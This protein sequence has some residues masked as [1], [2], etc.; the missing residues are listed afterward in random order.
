[1]GLVY[2][3]RAYSERRNKWTGS[4]RLI[5]RYTGLE[6]DKVK[7]GRQRTKPPTQKKTNRCR[8]RRR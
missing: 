6:T 8:D 1:M 7:T 3:Q 2:R 4:D 5:D